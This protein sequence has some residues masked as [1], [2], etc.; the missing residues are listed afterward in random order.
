[1]TESSC[2][3]VLTVDSEKTSDAN[4]MATTAAID[5]V[6]HYSVIRELDIPSYRTDAAP[7]LRQS[8]EAN[9]RN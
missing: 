7:Q 9:R 4:P 5:R 2:V 6:V 1:M 8:E 3:S